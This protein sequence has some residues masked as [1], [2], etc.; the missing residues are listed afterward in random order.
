[1][2]YKNLLSGNAKYKK[3]NKKQMKKIKT[4]TLLILLLTLAFPFSS[5][6]ERLGFEINANTSDVEGKIDV[7][8]PHYE[9]DLFAGVGGL[10]SEDN[11]FISNVNFF[12]RDEIFSPALTLGLGFKGVYGRAEIDDTD[13][14]LASLNFALLGRYDFRRDNYQLPISVEAGFSAATKPLCFNDTE[15]Y[16]DFSCTVYGHIVNNAAVLVG[17]RYL[18]IRFDE[19]AGEVKTRDHAIFF[20]CKLFL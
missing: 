7:R 19:G 20:G 8:I 18:D 16:I 11:Y 15:R 3:K 5:Y 2:K 17:G 14:D 1:M 10:Y 9:T 13:Y 6:G 12:L 4:L